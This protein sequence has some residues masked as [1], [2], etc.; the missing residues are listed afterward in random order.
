MIKVLKFVGQSVAKGLALVIAT[1][2]Y[3]TIMSG[4]ALLLANR[5]WQ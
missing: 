5:L 3:L 2:T 4:L 1:L